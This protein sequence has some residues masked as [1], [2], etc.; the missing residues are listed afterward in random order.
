MAERVIERTET[1]AP[2]DTVVVHDD[3]ADRGSNIG[4]IIA[5]IIVLLLL[6]FFGS[7]IFAGGSGGG[8]NPPTTNTNIQAPNP[9]G[10]Q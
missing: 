9:T 5:V 8:V 2:R 7:R 3:R 6:L 10:S 1:E 4:T